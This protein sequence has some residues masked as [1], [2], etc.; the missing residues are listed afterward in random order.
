MPICPIYG[1]GVLMVV[2]FFRP[3]A[4]TFLLLFF[5][6]ISSICFRRLLSLFTAHMDDI[7]SIT[8]STD[9]TKRLNSRISLSRSKSDKN[10]ENVGDGEDGGE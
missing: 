2:I 10:A 9:Q 4:H 7:R 8:I 6:E 5:L 3:I 1:F